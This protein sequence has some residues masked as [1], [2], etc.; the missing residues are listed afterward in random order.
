MINLSFATVFSKHVPVPQI[1]LSLVR[2]IALQDDDEGQL[3]LLSVDVV[4][5]GEGEVLPGGGQQWSVRGGGSLCGVPG[6]PPAL[7]G[8]LRP[9][10]RLPLL[11]RLPGLQLQ[12]RR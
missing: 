8:V 4:V 10:L 2:S 6:L 9:P 5:R 12:L 1:I 3:P 7:A 11:H